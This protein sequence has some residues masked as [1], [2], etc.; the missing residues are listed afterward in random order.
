MFTLVMAG[1]SGTRFWPASKERLPKQFLNIIGD[2]T[3]LQE[4]IH[5]ICPISEQAEV[6]VVVNKMHESIARNQL[7][8][9]MTNILAEP[10]GR[11]TAACIG[12]AA[13]HIS[14]INENSPIVVLPA[15]HY[16]ANVDNF[17]KCLQSAAEVANSNAI[18]TLGITPTRPETGYG[19]IKVGEEKGQSL[20]E[21]YFQAESFV[22]KPNNK[23]ALEYILSGSYLWNSGIYVFTAKTILSELKLCMPTLYQQLIEVDEAI[24]TPNYESVLECVYPRLES[25]SIDCGVME[26]TNTPIYVL[27]TNFGWSDVGSWESLYELKRQLHDSDGNL[28]IGDAVGIESKNNFIF[29]N[30]GRTISLLGV[31][32]LVVVDSKD[33]VLIAKRDRSQDIK[34]VVEGLKHS[35]RT[36]LC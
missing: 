11:N 27:K 8:N 3:M 22:E 29:S 20:G 9:T 31:R 26:R 23:T 7:G 10:V 33:T 13:I 36:N 35:G 4:T 1:G 18:V 21:S 19:Y 14:R 12:L 2:R 16:I 30:S 25:I 34:K 24:G 6:F 17:L 15:D 5:R 28:Y 32:D